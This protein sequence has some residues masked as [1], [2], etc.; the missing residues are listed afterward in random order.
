MKKVI[1]LTESEL[2]SLVKK[3]I[4]EDGGG[5]P[6]NH[7]INNPFWKEMRANIEGEGVETVKYVPNKSLVID[8]FGNLYTITKTDT[9]YSKA[10]QG[11]PNKPINKAVQGVPKKIK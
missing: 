6:S 4:N 7:P 2:I 11:V 3:V 1:R 10:V 5:I 9:Q 8:A